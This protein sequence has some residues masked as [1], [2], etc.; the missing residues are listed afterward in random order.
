[1]AKSP[2]PLGPDLTRLDYL[3][4]RFKD[5]WSAVMYARAISVVALIFALLLLVAAP[6]AVALPGDLDSSFDLDGRVTTDFGQQEDYGNAVAIQPDGKILVLA[7]TTDNDEFVTTFFLLRYDAAGALDTT[8]DGDGKLVITG[9]V[10]EVAVQGDGKILLG[11]SVLIHTPDFLTSDFAVARLNSDGTPDMTFSDDGLA[12]VDF[13]GHRDAAGA[14]ALQA[15]GKIVLA[16]GTGVNSSDR[17]FALA[18]FNDDGT[19]DTSFN[20]DGTQETNLFAGPEQAREIV[21]QANGKIVIGTTVRGKH[22]DT[23]DF[24]LARYK[25]DG[26]LDSSF[27]GDGSVRTSFI[28]DE[29]WGLALQSDGKILAAGAAAGPNGGDFALAR[30]KLSGRLDPT[31]SK[32][33]KLRTDFNGGEDDEA[34]AVLI[35]ANGRIVLAGFGASDVWALARYRSGGKLDPSFSGDGKKLTQFGSGDSRRVHQIYDAALQADGRIVATGLASSVLNQWD[36]GLAR[37]LTS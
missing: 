34:R 14:I 29:L 35:Q 31:F 8:F 28:H 27:S 19:L 12:T 23:G 24:G 11:G 32:D 2:R 1:M 37:Y 15:D 25:S 10:S 5:L 7:Q 9:P 3:R 6:T 20:G 13:D 33:G 36:V 16:G 17:A 18:R 4:S 21:V 22:M 30:Y 26:T